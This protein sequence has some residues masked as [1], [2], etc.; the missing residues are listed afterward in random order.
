M[1]TALM[2]VLVAIGGVTLSVRA[3]TAQ[4]PMPPSGPAYATVPQPAPVGPQPTP[5]N[6]PL[7]APGTPVQNPAGSPGVDTSLLMDNGLWDN[8]AVPACC[9]ICGGGCLR[10]TR[11]VHGTGRANL[12]SQPASRRWDWI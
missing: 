11:L 6:G 10:P 9:A 4:Q 1:K 12:Q 2:F 5:A 8:A 3:A 7:P